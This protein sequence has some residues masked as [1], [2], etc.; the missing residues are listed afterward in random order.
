MPANAITNAPTTAAT[1]KSLG[2]AH[3]DDAENKAA[4]ERDQPRDEWCYYWGA[5]TIA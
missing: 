3:V 1:V 2:V 4:H 5:C